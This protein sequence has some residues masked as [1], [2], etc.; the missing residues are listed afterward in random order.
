MRLGIRALSSESDSDALKKAFAKLN[1]LFKKDKDSVT[2]IA[3]NTLYVDFLNHWK[4]EW[5]Y[6]KEEDKKQILSDL[7][8]IYYENQLVLSSPVAIYN[9]KYSTDHRGVLLLEGQ[10]VDT[11]PQ[12]MME[13][14]K[15]PEEIA[16]AMKIA[17]IRSVYFQVER[18]AIESTH[19][20][21]SEW[22]FVLKIQ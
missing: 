3:L 9:G 21:T 7:E 11:E 15:S 4:E 6:W 17:S 19:F 1:T 20:I 12:L 16:S 5:A 22:D 18:E 13:A 8:T 2:A 10:P 14:S